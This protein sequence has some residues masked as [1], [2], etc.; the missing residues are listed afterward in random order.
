MAPPTGNPQQI[1]NAF[2][3]AKT[4]STRLIVPLYPK[5]RSEQA[6]MT[7][8]G[9]QLYVSRKGDWGCGRKGALNQNPLRVPS[10]II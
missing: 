1:P 9:A 5:V 6:R 3:L 7:E 4:D 8:M 2:I 10:I